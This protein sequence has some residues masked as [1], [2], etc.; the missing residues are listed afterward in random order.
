MCY[1][2]PRRWTTIRCSRSLFP[3]VLYMFVCLSVSPRIHNPVCISFYT[4]WFVY[5]CLYTVTCWSVCLYTL[6][7]SLCVSVSLLFTCLCLSRS[8]SHA[9][10]REHRIQ[11]NKSNLSHWRRLWHHCLVF[12]T[13]FQYF[14]CS[15]L[16]WLTCFWLLFLHE[17]PT[18]CRKGVVKGLLSVHM[19][20]V[21]N[22]TPRTH[23]TLVSGI[24][25][26]AEKE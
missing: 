2:L 21:V 18:T 9:C 7:V 14:L 17:T 13:S 15:V 10:P 6:F 1:P 4:L 24:H 8:P 3:L 26:S 16:E 5:V 11:G 20:S 12:I 23:H 22:V 25:C 19:A